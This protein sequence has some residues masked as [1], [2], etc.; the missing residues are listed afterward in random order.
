MKKN[1]ENQIN[2]V[3]KLE[4]IHISKLNRT[5]ENDDA[6]IREEE[7]CEEISDFDST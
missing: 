3:A 2:F 1:H 6:D 7:S 5:E 4:R